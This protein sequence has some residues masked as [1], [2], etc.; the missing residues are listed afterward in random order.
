MF[1]AVVHQI[2]Y[3]GPMFG[4]VGLGKGVKGFFGIEDVVEDV[5]E[6]DVEDV[7]EDVVDKL[8]DDV[9]AEDQV[10]EVVSVCEVVLVPPPPPNTDP[11]PPAKHR[12]HRPCL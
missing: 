2:G 11:P 12:P 8:V 1:G 9:I 10:L 5:V 6:D 7:V 3:L 4:G